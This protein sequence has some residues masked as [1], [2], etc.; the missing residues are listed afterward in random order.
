MWYSTA[1]LTHHCRALSDSLHPQVL[2][3]SFLF[4]LFLG[5]TFKMSYLFPPFFYLKLSQCCI[6]FMK[7]FLCLQFQVVWF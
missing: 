3:G 2:L 5:A 6:V 7:S 4:F 1:L